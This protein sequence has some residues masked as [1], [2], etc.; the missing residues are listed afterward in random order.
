MGQMV[1][2]SAG[3]FFLSYVFVVFLWNTRSLSDSWLR[4][5][6][7]A[8]GANSITNYATGRWVNVAVSTINHK[9]E[10]SPWNESNVHD[11]IRSKLPQLD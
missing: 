1:N 9:H 11:E 2:A 7:G 5:D 10:Q 8:R 6:L 4:R 3:S